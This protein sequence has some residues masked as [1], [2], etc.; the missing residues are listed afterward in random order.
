MSSNVV[1]IGA[2][3]TANAAGAGVLSPTCAA[4]LAD[5]ER[6]AELTRLRDLLAAAA[7]LPD[8]PLEVEVALAH[9]ALRIRAC[10][11]EDRRRKG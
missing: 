2:R 8:A 3:R 4:A 10:L 7:R 6:F 9:I 5:V 1:R 11:A